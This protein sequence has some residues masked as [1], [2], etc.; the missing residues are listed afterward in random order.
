MTGAGRLIRDAKR[1]AAMEQ[2]YAVRPYGVVSTASNPERDSI[3]YLGPKGGRTVPVT[4][5]YLG[6]SSW[7]RVMPERNTRMILN[8]RADSGETFTSAYMAEDSAQG[9][10][11]STYEDHRFFYRRLQE[12][13]IDITST[14]LAGAHFSKDGTLSL[15]GGP[16]TSVLDVPRME[17]NVKAPTHI[18]RALDNNVSEISSETRFGVVKR[19]TD[20]EQPQELWVKVTP[21]GGSEV[22]AKEYLRNISSK[23]PPYTLVDHREGHVVAND[24][25]EPTSSVT[26]KKL[27]SLTKF[28]TVR[29]EETTQ[30]VDV[31]GNVS[32][33]LPDNA[34]YGFS[35]DVRRTD[36]KI[37]AGRDIS[38]SSNRNVLVDAEQTAEIEGSEVKLGSGATTQG[39]ALRGEDMRSWLRDAVVL[40]A[41][42]PARFLSSDVEV[43]FTNVLSSKVF[44]E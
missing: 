18:H 10:I 43:R 12:G 1:L 16:L 14:G 4:H 19:F 28:G 8:S 25:T 3:T 33:S 35:M 15:R 7:I 34:S 41:T 29:L 24:G 38:L 26:G 9:L 39:A 17:V 11:R 21:E 23:A 27:R 44:V 22:F 40:T 42:G 31:E 20:T 5:P 32:W 13:E 2:Q 30:E 36:V 6:P 37:N